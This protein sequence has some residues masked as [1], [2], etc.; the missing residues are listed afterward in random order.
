[1]GCAPSAHG[2]GLERQRWEGDFTSDGV[3][4][5]VQVGQ[6]WR[7]LASVTTEWEH[8]ESGRKH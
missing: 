2:T 7:L 5:V 1:M 4:K 6:F 8:E 3:T